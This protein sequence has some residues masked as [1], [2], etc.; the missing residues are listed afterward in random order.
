ML[1][2]KEVDKGNLINCTWVT[3]ACSTHHETALE[4]KNNLQN[5]E[6]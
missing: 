6:A 4:E 3:E 2:L 5:L 1:T